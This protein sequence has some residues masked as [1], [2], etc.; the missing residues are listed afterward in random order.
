METKI[1][2]RTAELDRAAASEFVKQVT[3]KPSSVIGLSTGRTT[4]PIHQTITTMY[5]Q[6]PFDTS[7]LVLFALD[8]IAGV[9]KEYFGA[10]YTMIRNEIADS[11]HIPDER[12]ITLPVKSEHW[13]KDFDS[14]V[15]SIASHGGIDLLFLGL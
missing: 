4:G 2:N 9:P 3:L 15:E 13:E 10:C 12:L 11:L 8:E 1:F 5:E 7:S 14:F 6:C